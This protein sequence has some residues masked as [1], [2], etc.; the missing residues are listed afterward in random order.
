MLRRYL[1]KR[2][3]LAVPLLFGITVLTFGIL[4]LA[5]GGPTLAQTAFNPKVSPESIQ[6]MRQLYGMDKPLPVQYLG[7]LG[8][9]ARFDLGVSF[10]DRRPVLE[11]VL[12]SLPATLLLSGL[13]FVVAYGVGVPMGVYTALHAGRRRDRLAT[14]LSFLAYALPAFVLALFCQNL[15]A[16]RLGLMPISGFRSP[17]SE[18]W[19]LWRQA[20]DVLWHMAL[21]LAVTAFG[22]WVATAQFARNSLLEALSQDYVRFARAK[23]L[24]ERR[25]ILGHA[26]PNAMLPLVTLL[27]L[28]LPALIGGSFIIESIFAWPGMGRLGY[29]AAVNYDYPVVM[30]V[31][32]MGAL[33]TVLG[34]LL[35]DVGYAVIDPRVR[36]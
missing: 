1:I 31:A 22:S 10:R 11:R 9:L 2:L 36:Y 19:P 29:E 5:P 27:G 25:V 23:G 21:P 18:A 14:L 35:A 6:E 16:G 33:L 24:P 7:W 20:L 28:Q 32:F 8:R 12:E 34:N 13:G 30:G 3:L 26:L 17:W 15:L 4:H